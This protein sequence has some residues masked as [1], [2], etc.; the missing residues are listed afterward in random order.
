M[1]SRSQV[2]ARRSFWRLINPRRSVFG[3]L[4]LAS[5]LLVAVLLGGYGVALA[6][7]LAPGQLR[8]IQLAAGAAI[9]SALAAMLVAGL[10]LSRTVLQPLRRMEGLAHCLVAGAV[11]EPVQTRSRDEVGQLARVFNEAAQYLRREI[12][13]LSGLYHISLMMGSGTEVSQV[14]ELLT[15]KVARLLRAEMCLILLY[16]E[17][18]RSLQAQLPACGVSDEHLRL[19]RARLDEQNLATQVFKTGE[20]YLTNQV[21]TDPLISK[22][23]TELLGVRT[24]LAV[25]LLAGN[26]ALGTLEIMN[27][28][29]GFLEE[30]KRLAMVF[31]SQAAHLL[32]QAQLFEQLRESEECYRQIFESTLDGLYRS[33][34]DGQLVTVNPAL[35]AMLGYRG[36][37]E[38]L[39][40]N[41]MHDLLMDQTAAQQLR[42]EL[43][44]CGQALDVECR[45][46]RRSGEAVPARLSVRVV[47]D[48]A[49]HY[50]LGI[51]KDITEQKRLAEQLV[52]SE[53]LAAIGELVAGLAHEVRN[54][55]FD[56]T[57]TLSAL[58]RRLS[59]RETVQPYLEVVK[60]EAER[61]NY[62]M[63]Q[64]LEHSRPIWLDEEPAD[65]GNVIR[66][67]MDQFSEQAHQ[68]GV[69]LTFDCPAGVPSL[70]FDRHKMHKAFANLLDN[71]LQ[72]TPA[73]G[74]V[75]IAIEP[76]PNSS[77]TK[78]HQELQIIISDT[79]T[80][81]LAENLS[82][83]F[84]P[85]FT[86]RATGTGLG[87][88]ITRKTI[89]DHGGTIAVHSEP[90]KGTTFTIRLP[91]GE[92][93]QAECRAKRLVRP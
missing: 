74:Q 29:G 50:H 32:F 42:E 68:R 66:N 37:E 24:V 85:F 93:V 72:H 80:G 87:L 89:H 46:R 64:L 41:L 44:A 39:G 30:D 84:D 34:T 40:A 58:S 3:K 6:L 86:T 88:A 54:P 33:T 75:R 70:R 43:T 18:D 19:L 55:L 23:V 45:L 7:K 28:Q 65:L 67:A 15:H 12:E 21:Q 9:L 79:G 14:C 27:K 35:V 81:I 20:A 31:A 26:R 91:T 62:L 56:I 48:Q 77:A 69:T 63:E 90:E 71:A 25:P 2:V 76:L 1:E 5:L 17:R 78:K 52:L 73:G 59:D 4:L 83:V 49:N 11:F 92:R 10:I 16:D 38:L 22:S 13:W 61:L 47:T 53:R 82:R 8:M 51:V 60:A 36:P 57:T